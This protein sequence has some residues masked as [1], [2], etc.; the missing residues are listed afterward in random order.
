MAQLSSWTR[1]SYF[2]AR[3]ICRCPNLG[4]TTPHEQRRQAYIHTV[5]ADPGS[6]VATSGISV[7]FCSCGYLDI[8]VLRVRYLAVD[9]VLA[10][11]GCP[12]RKSMVQRLLDSSPW[13]IAASHVLHRLLPPRH[14]PCALT[15]LT[16][17][18]H[19]WRRKAK[20]QA[21]NTT[22][23]LDALMRSSTSQPSHAHCATSED[24]HT[25]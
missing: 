6:L 22:S 25:R 9:W 13:L 24:L 15:N 17:M 18:T 3:S 19:P 21:T 10:Q 23:K 16:A 11:T 20:P 14:P 4:P 1:L 12:I 2:A 5:W 7:D 8:S